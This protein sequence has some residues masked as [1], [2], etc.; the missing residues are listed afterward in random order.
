[1][2]LAC[3]E[4]AIFIDVNGKHWSGRI[5]SMEESNDLEKGMYSV[6]SQEEGKMKI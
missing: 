6:D 2:E 1:M 5:I 3:W 4:N